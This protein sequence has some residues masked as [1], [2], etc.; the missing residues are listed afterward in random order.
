MV[1]DIGRPPLSGFL[2]LAVQDFFSQASVAQTRL[3][4][5]RTS[6]YDGALNGEER[7]WVTYAR[8]NDVGIRWIAAPGTK[9]EDDEVVYVHAHGGAF[10]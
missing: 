8:I 5:N 4:F 3:A 7:T 1:Q 9:R 10:T 6:S 2:A